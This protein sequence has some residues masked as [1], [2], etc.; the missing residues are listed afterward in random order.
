M[1]ITLQFTNRGT[2]AT[3]LTPSIS[4]WDLSNDTLQFSNTMTETPGGIY[5]YDFS[6]YDHN[7]DYSFLVDGGDGLDE[8]DRWQWGGND[9]AQ[10]TSEL[11]II[12]GLVQR[13]QRI[14]NCTYG[15]NGELLSATLTIYPSAAYAEAESD[16]ITSFSLTATYDGSG[17]MTDYLVKEL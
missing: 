10:V 7:V 2:P 13:N 6:G 15:S 8:A 11:E 4:A 16:A 9:L 1:L 5:K 12:A 3:G 14:T 17:N